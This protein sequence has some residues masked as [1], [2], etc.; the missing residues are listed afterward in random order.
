MSSLTP[1]AAAV[2]EL[3]RLEERAARLR[4]LS[5]AATFAPAELERVAATYRL[6]LELELA[7]TKAVAAELGVTRYTA[8]KRVQRARLAKLLGPTDKG[9]KGEAA[10]EAAG[11]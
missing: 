2:L 1:T 11:P 10:I 7:P 4:A 6:A 8:A 9:R 3:E 5:A